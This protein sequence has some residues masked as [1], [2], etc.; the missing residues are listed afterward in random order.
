MMIRTHHQQGRQRQ[1]PPRRPPPQRV[2]PRAV[3]VHLTTLSCA[4]VLL[5]LLLQLHAQLQYCQGFTVPVVVS[6]TPAKFQNNYDSS[7]TKK[8]PT[9]GMMRMFAPT[10]ATTTSIP[11]TGS[12]RSAPSLRLSSRS[13]SSFPSSLLLEMQMTEEPSEPEPEPKPESGGEETAAADVA[14][15]ASTEDDDT[16]GE[17]SKKGIVSSSSSSSVQS[18][19]LTVPLFLKFIAVLLIKFLTDLVVYPML[20]LYRLARRTKR[21]LLSMI[22]GTSG[23]SGSGS[24]GRSSNIKPNGSA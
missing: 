1:Q 22:N 2:A 23:T 21:K 8:S 16:A 24:S 15:A 14:A 10:T 19:L 3:V 4:A 9:T 7:G 17:T 12:F 13:V 20:L 11:N 6:T 5:L 18:K